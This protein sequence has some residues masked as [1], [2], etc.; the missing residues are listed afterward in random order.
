MK[1][2]VF[3]L[4][5]C[6][7]PSFATTWYV[8]PTGNDS[9]SGLTESASLL[10]IQK[11]IDQSSPNDTILVAEGE[12]K[13][14]TVPATKAPLQ[15]KAKGSVDRTI[16]KAETSGNGKRCVTIGSGSTTNVYINGFTLTGAQYSDRSNW[17]GAGAFGGTYTDCIISNNHCS[18]TAAGA[19]KCCLNNCL[20]SDNTCSDWTGGIEQC[21]ASNCIIRGNSGLH[22]TMQASFL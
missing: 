2:I 15:I 22:G 13:S 16:I 20:I 4:H 14:I 5:L 7:L 3:I 6:A 12:Y 9:N 8:S 11:A 21:V 1:K 18:S 17:G 10:T 19:Y